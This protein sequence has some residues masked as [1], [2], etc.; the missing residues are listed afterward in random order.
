MIPL[1]PFAGAGALTEASATI[2]EK[3]ILRKRGIDYRAYTVYGFLAISLIMLVVLVLF[4]NSLWKIS[5]EAFQL[6]NVLIMTFIIICAGAANLFTF[7]AM[8][9]EKITEMEPLRLFQPL[10]VIVFAFI[11]YVSERHSPTPMIIAAVIASLALIFSHIKRHHFKLNK[12]LVATLLGSLLFAL[13]LAASKA[14]LPY[15]SNLTFYFIR[16]SFI[17]V[18]TFI[19]LKPN[20]KEI[21]KKSWFYMILASAIWI[22]YRMFLY[23]GYM[24]YGVIF[25]TLIF[26]TGV[27]LIYVFASIFLKEKWTWRNIISTIIILSCVTWAILTNS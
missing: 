17:F 23:F 16:C 2:I 10:L 7:Y 21:D 26:I 24:H 13:E 11:F 18:I 3:N 14:V 22:I 8:K 27:I 25:T 4:Q 20:A 1:I 19:M 5:D 6:K 15:Y 9:W 12:Y